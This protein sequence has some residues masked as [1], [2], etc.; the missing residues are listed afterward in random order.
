MTTTTVGIAATTLLPG[1]RFLLWAHDRTVVSVGFPDPAEVESEYHEQDY[2]RKIAWVTAPQEIGTYPVIV[3]GAPSGRTIEVAQP[4]PERTRVEIAPGDDWLPHIATPNTELVLLPGR[5][6]PAGNYT[7]ASNVGVSADVAGTVVVEQQPHGS[8]KHRIFRPADFF[9]LSRLAFEGTSEDSYICHQHPTTPIR[10][11]ISDCTFRG[12]VLGKWAGPSLVVERCTFRNYQ[13]LTALGSHTLVIDCLIQGFGGQMHTKGAD[14]LAVVR[15]RWDGTRRGL[16]V[17]TSEGP[18]THCLFYMLNFRNVSWEQNGQEVFMVEGDAAAFS[19]N[20][21]RRHV[22][23]HSNSV[24]ISLYASHCFDNLFEEIWINGGQ[25]VVFSGGRGNNHNNRFHCVEL[26]GGTFIIEEGHDN[27]FDA[28]WVL[29]PIP[30]RDNA[31]IH[32]RTSTMQGERNFYRPAFDVREPNVLRNCGVS[33]AWPGFEKTD[34]AVIEGQFLVNP[35]VT[36]A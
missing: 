25:G 13:G 3:N 10:N 32:H 33:G 15:C 6:K 23:E 16:Y 8:Y 7:C 20:L 22:H 17:H 28:C 21:I 24:G 35:A 31:D 18:T 19:K 9:T 12:I 5:H 2:K 11:R 1:E 36:A 30:S 29:N 27:L 34:A 14:S 26:I 4:P